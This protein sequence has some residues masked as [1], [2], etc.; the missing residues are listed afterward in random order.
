MIVHCNYLFSENMIEMVGILT[1]QYNYHVVLDVNGDKQVILL[2][3]K[4]EKNNEQS[5]AWSLKKA[6]SC[7]KCTSM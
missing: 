7:K 5:Q 2:P 4:T 1:R 3:K 6:K